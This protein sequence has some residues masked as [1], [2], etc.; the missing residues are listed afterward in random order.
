MPPNLNEVTGARDVLNN[1]TRT[2][3]GDFRIEP[4]EEEAE[5]DAPSMV[6]DELVDV[7]DRRLFLLPG[8]LVELRYPLVSA[9]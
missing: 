1:L 4:D 5:N 6:Y 8:D 2:N 7:G 3:D 9:A